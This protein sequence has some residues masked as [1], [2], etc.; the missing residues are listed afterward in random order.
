A[1]AFLIPV[2]Q[3]LATVRSRS[4][5][6]RSS[7]APK[8]LDVS[9]DS[10]M[11]SVDHETSKLSKLALNERMPTSPAERVASFAAAIRMLS[12]YRLKDAPVS[13]KRS[14]PAPVNPGRFCTA[15]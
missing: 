15:S 1:P 10:L 4:M 7:F 5:K 3:V 14:L 2:R 9:L 8:P 6:R 13:L 12:T 11:E